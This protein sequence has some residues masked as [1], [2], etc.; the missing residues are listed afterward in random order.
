MSF[1]RYNKHIRQ[2]SNTNHS[3]LTNVSLILKERRIKIM[4]NFNSEDFNP[5]NIILVK[6]DLS[7]LEE[8][9]EIFGEIVASR[10]FEDGIQLFFLIENGTVFPTEKFSLDFTEDNP[11]T[12]LIV[13][14]GPTYEAPYFDVQSLVGRMVTFTYKKSGKQILIEKIFPIADEWDDVI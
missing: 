10:L 12:A 5:Q 9:E 13:E 8:R 14:F 7:S 3:N 1:I 4:S 6:K 2:K 11:L